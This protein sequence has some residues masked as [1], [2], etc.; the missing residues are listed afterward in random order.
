MHTRLFPAR[1]R[2][3]DAAERRPIGRVGAV[4]F[5][6][7]SDLGRGVFAEYPPNKI[8][9]RIDRQRH[10]PGH[11]AGVHKLADVVRAAPLRPSSSSG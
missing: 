4:I 1:R 2:F 9:R 6:Q 11:H 7:S 10:A 3:H 8:Q 5:D